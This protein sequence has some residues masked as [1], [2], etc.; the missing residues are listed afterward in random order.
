MNECENKVKQD[1]W[2]KKKPPRRDGKTGARQLGRRVSDD[3]RPQRKDGRNCFFKKENVYWSSSWNKVPP[4]SNLWVIGSKMDGSNSH[5]STFFLL[6]PSLTFFFPRLPLPAY[7][8]PPSP[9]A[10]PS[11][12]PVALARHAGPSRRRLPAALGHPGTGSGLPPPPGPAAA[13]PLPTPSQPVVA[14]PPPSK[15]DGEQRTSRQPQN[16]KLVGISPE[17]EEMRI[18]VRRA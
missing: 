16:P 14:G 5:I 6:L 11:A 13:S 3:L 18:W 10:T 8:P 9:T 1:F 7:H 4:C 17:L 2:Q 15:V 12:W